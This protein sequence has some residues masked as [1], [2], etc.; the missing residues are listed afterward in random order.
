MTD[1]I[2]EYPFD[3]KIF[4]NEMEQTSALNLDD[5]SYEMEMALNELPGIH[6]IYHGAPGGH[7]AAAS[8]LMAIAFM[9]GQRVRDLQDVERYHPAII[10][11]D[12]A[13]KLMEGS[14]ASAVPVST[15]DEYPEPHMEPRFSPGSEQ[16]PN[17]LLFGFGLE[18][19]ALQNAI[20]L[21]CDAHRGQVDKAGY[22]Y[23]WHVLRV[24]ISLLPDIAAAQVGILHDVFEDAPPQFRP[25]AK[26]LLGQYLAEAVQILTHA[27]IETYACYIERILEAPGPAGELVRKVKRAD[28]ADNLNPARLAWLLPG[29]RAKLEARYR[30][31]LT[32]LGDKV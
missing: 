4:R 1:P 14:W 24:G 26:Q 32:I 23:L 19:R 20:N 30:D 7:F 18:F 3:A 29:E 13:Q 21:A 17:A 25:I 15:D 9:A 2:S 11:A 27:G 22:P 12:T 6:V 31:A 16:H 10:P 28:L 5:L 8:R